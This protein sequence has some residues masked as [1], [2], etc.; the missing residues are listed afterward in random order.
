MLNSRS[1][2]TVAEHLQSM[3]DDTGCRAEMT[4]YQAHAVIQVIQ[5]LTL[6]PYERLLE[7]AKVEFAQRSS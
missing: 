6:T 2:K 1:Q 3:L 4:A 7:L 5:L